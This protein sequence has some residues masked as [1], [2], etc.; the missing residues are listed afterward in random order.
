MEKRTNIAKIVN[1][2][3]GVPPQCSQDKRKKIADE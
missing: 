1:W 2:F 3:V